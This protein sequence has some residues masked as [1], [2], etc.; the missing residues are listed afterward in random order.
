MATFPR[1]IMP[2]RYSVPEVPRG[3]FSF[4]ESGA[5]HLRT[6]QQVGRIWEEEWPDLRLGDPDVDAFLAWLEWAQMTQDVFDVTHPALPGSGIAPHG[7]GGG[8]PLV[9]GASQ[10][11]TSLVTDGWTPNITKVVAGGD[12]IKL[13]GLT[14]IY[15]VRDDVNSNGSGQATLIITPAIP[16]GSSPADN[17]AIT[18]TGCTI[19][20]VIWPKFGPPAGRVGDLISELT[21]GFR[22]LP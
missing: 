6:T 3:M 14:P 16:A 22:E 7:A 13:A 11:G 20:A 19:R 1:T 12:V 10:T 17:A 2:R 21:V 18:R 9:N 8:T 4:G 15:R 5:G